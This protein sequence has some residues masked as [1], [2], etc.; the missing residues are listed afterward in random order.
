MSTT[1]LAATASIERRMVPRLPG[2]RGASSATQMAP[3]L[4]APAAGKR[5]QRCSNT[6]S[7]LCGLSLPA[8]L[9]RREGETSRHSAPAPSA[10]RATSAALGL[11]RL[12]AKNTKIFG[13]QPAA[14]AVSNKEV[15]SA[16][17]SPVS[18]RTLRISSARISL[19][20]SFWGLVMARVPAR[21]SG[22]ARIA[23][24]AAEVGAGQEPA[25][26]L[27]DDGQLAAANDPGAR[28]EALAHEPVAGERRGPNGVGGEDERGAPRGQQGDAIAQQSR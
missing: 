7:M 17:N 23:A 8:S 21:S 13:S 24:P 12:S 4:S 1:P 25:R 9:A 22:R 18:R 26:R 5:A 16:T 15:P 10:Q 20:R 27:F 19:T 6:P 2:S 28:A 3:W 14:R 11:S